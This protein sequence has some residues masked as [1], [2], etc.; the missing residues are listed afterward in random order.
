MALPTGFLM[1]KFG[2]YAYW[3]L[4]YSLLSL[5]TL[6]DITFLYESSYYLQLICMLSVL[7]I[8]QIDM[9]INL[10][11]AVN[12]LLLFS[13]PVM[14]NSL[15]PLGLQH[16]S[17]PCPSPSPSLPKFMFIA[18]V[19][20]SSHLIL[21]CPLLLLPSIFPRIRDFSNESSVCIR[22]PKYWSFSFS[23]S[24]S[25]E[26]SGLISLKIDWFDVL[27]FQGT[28]RCSA[29][30]MV[31]VSQLY[32]MTGKTITL[33]LCTFVSRVMPL[34]FSILSMFVFTFLPRSKCF[35]IS[36]LQSLSAVIT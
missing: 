32:V 5:T 22:W 36:R 15:Q 4:G 6:N 14:Y 13:H 18:S 28:L 29:F 9:N 31:Q 19:I 1:T 3:L 8:R 35:L 2:D 26:N 33:T 23:I 11:A 21:W 12:V 34:L 25:S 7:H 16:T 24:P 30:F 20:P 10:C 17:P 27:A